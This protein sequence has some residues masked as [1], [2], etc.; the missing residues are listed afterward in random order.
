[1]EVA[2]GESLGIEP[3]QRPAREHLAQQPVVLAVGAVDPVDAVRF[4]EPCALLHPGVQKR[5]R[6]G[7]IAASADVLQAPFERK[8]A[9][10]V[11]RSPPGVL[12]AA[13]FLFEP[14]HNL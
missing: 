13:Y 10:I 14:G 1:M 9:A 4:A 3:V 12:V 2:V 5:A 7:F 11:V 6:I 8:D